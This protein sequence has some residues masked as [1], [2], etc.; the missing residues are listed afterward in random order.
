MPDVIVLP[1]TQNGFDMDET[2][3]I[4]QRLDEVLAELKMVR[5]EIAAL[6]TPAQNGAAMSIEDAAKHLGVSKGT[7][8]RLCQDG[9]MPHN[10]IGRRVTITPDQI[11][12]YQSCQPKAGQLR[13]V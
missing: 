11:A 2:P 10:K 5:E 9:L 13:Y 12:E 6:K 1:L 8:Y 4:Q 7:L 3:T